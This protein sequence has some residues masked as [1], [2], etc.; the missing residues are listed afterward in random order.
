MNEWVDVTKSFSEE[1]RHYKNFDFD[2]ASFSD[3]IP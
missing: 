1:D 2:L 3:R